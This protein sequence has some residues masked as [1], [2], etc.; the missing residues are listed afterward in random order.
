MIASV[1]A[2]LA[3]SAS[4]FAQ[5]PT[6]VEPGSFEN[7]G[8]EKAF[9]AALLAGA[10]CGNDVKACCVPANLALFDNIE[11]ECK[12][13]AGNASQTVQMVVQGY[14]TTCAGLTTGTGL[15]DNPACEKS[16]IAVLNFAAACGSDVAK[17]CASANSALMDKMEK[18]CKNLP[19]PSNQ[20]IADTITL[21]RNTCKAAA[22][23]TAKAASTKAATASAAA[24][25]VAVKSGAAGRVAGAVGAVAAL[26]FI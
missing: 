26:V 1:V 24:S 12:S 22:T 15:A 5:T 18:D 17:C 21:Y 25:S 4:G 16:Y 2:L 19:A 8:C 11:K 9:N 6:S 7:P 3:L 13:L 23:G 10:A 20:G 14:R